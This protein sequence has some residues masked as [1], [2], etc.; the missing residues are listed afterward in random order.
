MQYHLQTYEVQDFQ[1]I[2]TF[3]LCQGHMIKKNFFLVH[4]LIVAK[5]I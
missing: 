5:T 2:L 4:S 1:P 3:N